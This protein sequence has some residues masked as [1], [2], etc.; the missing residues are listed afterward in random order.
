MGPGGRQ[1]PRC[2]HGGEPG[3]AGRSH[4]SPDQPPVQ[5]QVP[6]GVHTPCS[7]PAGQSRSS[8]RAPFQPEAHA[9]VPLAAQK[10]RGHPHAVSTHRGACWSH[11]SPAQACAHTHT[12]PAHVPCWPHSTAHARPSHASP[13][14]PAQHLQWPSGRQSPCAL[15]SRGHEA[16]EQSRESQPSLHLHTLCSHVPWPEQSLGHAGSAHEGP[17][18][19]KPH[20]HVPLMQV[21]WPLHPVGHVRSAHAAPTKP[22]GH[23]HRSGALHVPPFSH[24]GEHT[25]TEQSLPCQP[26]SH[27]QPKRLCHTLRVPWP[28]Q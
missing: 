24:T 1:W 28:E 25:G 22:A 16:T 4:R 23:S 27:W 17:L 18:Q 10:P 14:Q 5:K 15:Q 20:A 2:E 26:A 21:P 9:H 8:Q 3:H 7:H 11:R 19:S 13:I 6:E 12:P